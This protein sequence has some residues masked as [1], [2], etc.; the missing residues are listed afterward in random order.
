ML[1]I[2]GVLRVKQFW[3]EA[4]SD[5]EGST[6]GKKPRPEFKQLATFLED[7]RYPI[8]PEIV[9][10]ENESML[11]KTGTNTEIKTWF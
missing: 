5:A 6:I 8:G 10:W 7:N 2:S 9:F 3:P 1:T 4:R 11:V